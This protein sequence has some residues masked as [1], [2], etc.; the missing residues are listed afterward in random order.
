MKKTA[1]SAAIA[2]PALCPGDTIGLAPVAGPWQEEKFAEGVRILTANGFKV[3]TPVREEQNYLAGSDQYRLKV[4]HELW[5]NPEIKAVMAIRGGYGCL[6]LVDRLDFKL[7]RRHPKILVG[8]SD[9]T[10]LLTAVGQQTGLVT[11]HGPMLTT[12]G[13]TDKTCLADLCKRLTT[14]TPYPLPVDKAQ[15]LRQGTAG[16]QLV[17]GNLTTICH[18]LATP[19]ELRLK[20][21]ILFIEDV[22]EA[23][24]RVDRL[25]TQLSLSGG[26]GE[27]SGLILGTFSN[28]GDIKLIWQRVMELVPAD[29]PVWADFPAGHTSRNLTLP[30]G[31]EAIMDSAA[32]TLSFS[33]P[34][35]LPAC[36]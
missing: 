18:L 3:K 31:I 27:I 7:I 11:F 22:G 21:R 29:I 5:Q 14:S 23:P 2:P 20:N 32:G 28:C 33:G 34:C 13:S 25:L 35:V 6:R 19:Y 4:F 36:A 30:L 17:G 15:I 1:D 26:L 12:L 8:F 24:Y 16:G 9:V 10:V